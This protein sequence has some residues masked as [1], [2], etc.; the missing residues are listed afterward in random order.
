MSSFDA[1][2][3]VMM[4]HDVMFVWKETVVVVVVLVDDI[5][6]SD[7][8]K[9]HVCWKDDDDS[10]HVVLWDCSTCDVSFRPLYHDDVVVRLSCVLYRYY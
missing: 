8:V 5:L 3:A 2:M 7:V 6:Y 9:D 1:V 10:P 4:M